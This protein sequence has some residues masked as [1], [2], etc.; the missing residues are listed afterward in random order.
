[1]IERITEGIDE[2]SRVELIL[3][4]LSKAFDSVSHQILL[5]KLEF[6]GIRGPALLLL[7]S[8]LEGR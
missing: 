5:Q 6:F 4:D 2:G 8:F 3:C 7:T 1:M